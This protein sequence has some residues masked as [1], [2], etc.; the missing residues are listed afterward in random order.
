MRGKG[1]GNREVSRN[2]ILELRGDPRGAE[3][4]AIPKEGARGGTWFPHGSDPQGSDA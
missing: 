3:L 4:E 2:F 1:S